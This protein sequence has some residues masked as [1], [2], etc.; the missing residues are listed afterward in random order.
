MS[1]DSAATP[2]QMIYDLLDYGKMCLCDHWRINEY[3]DL[4]LKH[5]EYCEAKALRESLERL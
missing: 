2:R 4:E 1:A 5:D 3:N